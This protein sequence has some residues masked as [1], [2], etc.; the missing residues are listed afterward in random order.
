[1]HTQQANVCCAIS[2]CWPPRR[3]HGENKTKAEEEHLRPTFLSK[4]PV[5]DFRQSCYS[6]GRLQP[7]VTRMPEV[8]ARPSTAP[9]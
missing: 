6:S 9:D 8:C 1:M 2:A 4:V 3:S 7:T 5:N